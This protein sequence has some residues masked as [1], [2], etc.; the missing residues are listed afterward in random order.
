MTINIKD[1]SKDLDKLHDLARELN[2]RLNILNTKKLE[3]SVDLLV[4]F[5]ITANEDFEVENAKRIITIIEPLIL[6]IKLD[7][8][9]VNRATTEFIEY[10]G[11]L[12]TRF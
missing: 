2:T 12:K 6:K 10:L 11:K 8:P 7:H 4:R 5:V 3:D 9:E 1:I